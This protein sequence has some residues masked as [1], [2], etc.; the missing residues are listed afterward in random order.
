MLPMGLSGSITPLKGVGSPRVEARFLVEDELIYRVHLARAPVVD[1]PGVRPR[2]EP[3]ARSLRSQVAL[4]PTHSRDEVSL[5]ACRLARAPLDRALSAV[6]PAGAAH[7][8]RRYE[9][10]APAHLLVELPQA[11]DE[12]STWVTLYPGRL[13][14]I[15]TV[16]HPLGIGIATQRSP[17]RDAFLVSF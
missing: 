2:S 8:E 5:R 17:R 10:E 9:L 3:C 16:D 7:P 15:R 14:V 12:S 4:P 13:E 1:T 6:P 11:S